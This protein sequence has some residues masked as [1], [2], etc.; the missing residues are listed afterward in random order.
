MRI[1]RELHAHKTTE[2][3]RTH[4][5]ETLEHDTVFVTQFS[6]IL[7]CNVSHVSLFVDVDDAGVTKQ[8]PCLDACSAVDSPP[9]LVA[10][11]VKSRACVCQR[12][13]RLKD[14]TCVGKAAKQFS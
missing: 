2:I 5:T 3:T 7:R 8:S 10:C 14:N 4:T 1:I 11:D 6:A 13:F 9:S 12:G